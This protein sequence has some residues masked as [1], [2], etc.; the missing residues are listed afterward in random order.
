MKKQ[1]AFHISLLEKDRDI[2]LGN[3]E[4]KKRE[5]KAVIK[6]YQL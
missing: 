4:I 5:V 2:I 6:K 1:M 3:I